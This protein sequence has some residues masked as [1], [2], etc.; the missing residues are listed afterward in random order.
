MF[1]PFESLPPTARVWIFQANRPFTDEELTTVHSRLRALTEEWSVHGSPLETSYS[2]R[3]D[4]FIVLAADESGQS[5]SGCSIDNSVRVL[6]ALEESFGI[7]LFDRNQV[8]FKSGD[9]V[10]LVPLEELKQKFQDRILNQD[11]LT[12]NN[13]AGTRSEFDDKWLVPAGETWLSR[14]IPNPL[15]KLN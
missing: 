6:K 5:A 4:Q 8:A 3:F 7:R 15:V 10:L 1:V 2:V 14:Y 11:S 12:F 9:H 13:L